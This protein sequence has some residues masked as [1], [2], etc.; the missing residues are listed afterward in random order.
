M[1]VAT[2]SHKRTT[3]LDR[4]Y[5]G[6]TY[7]PEHWSVDDRANDAARMAAAGFNIVRMAEFAWDYL[8]PGEGVYQFD[9]FDEV[10]AALGAKGIST[11][12]CTPT[13][14]PPRWLTSAHPDVLR[15]N[16]EGVPMQH[17]SRQHVCPSGETFRAYSRAITRAMA[18]HYVDNPYVVGWQTDNELNC[19]FSECHCA[20]CQTA[21]RDYLRRVYEG[22][23]AS[24]NR[25]WG[26]TFWAQSYDDFDEID[27]PKV[28]RPAYPNPAHQ[29][30]YFRFISW[31]TTRFQHEQV[32]ILREAAP[33][34]FVTHNG[35]FAHIDYRGPFGRDLDFLGYDVYPFFDH[36]P[37]HRPLSQAFNLDH[38]RAWTGNF[39]VPEQQSGPGGQAP[40]LH[41]NP[42]PGE[43]RRM[44]Y[45]SIAHG[46]DS[47]LFFRWRTCRFGAEE[48]WCGILDHDNEPRRR[49]DEVKALG[50][51]LS[52]VGAEVLGTRVLVDIGIAAADVDVYD[53]HSTMS[54]GLPSPRQAAEAVHGAFL[55]RGYAVGCV[56]PSDDLSDLKVY[57]IPHW[58]LFTPTWLPNLESFV[59]RGGV[60][61]IGALTATRDWHNAVVPET[62]PGLLAKLAGVRVGEYGRQNAPDIRPLPL[63][64]Y[65]GDAQPL[66]RHWYEVLDPVPGT[67]ICA[68]WMG[69]HLRLKAAVTER[70]VGAGAVFYV[71]TYLDDALVDALIPFLTKER[72]DLTQ[73]WP[74]LPSGV[75][76]VV[77]QDDAKLLWFVINDGDSAA[78]VPSLPPGVD[79][80]TGKIV[81][82]RTYMQP[83]GVMVIKECL[84]RVEQ[85]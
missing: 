16:A 63:R 60:L 42:E 53:G 8:E 46:A 83:Y 3:R 43:I 55:E 57:V 21:F 33:R 38:A 77:R 37:T 48:Y 41:D 80:L 72:P 32:E 47:L 13:A 84:A 22:D 51:E 26:T 64:F 30:D 65:P 56:H 79:L 73:L 78:K 17:G 85:E 59:E 49:Y 27:T 82:G 45:T 74:G 4:F 67:H 58:A 36:D 23:I 6:A 44:A 35:T 70:K 76:V 71:G 62:P 24:L 7:Y 31:N 29:L 11:M 28:A 10:S 81:S 52:T 12:L 20:N 15:V 14:T 68:R 40:Y 5:Y 25:A 54:M 61:V 2:P 34:W 19:H 18:E 69:R 1:T 66:S 50:S 39:I 9:L 75:H